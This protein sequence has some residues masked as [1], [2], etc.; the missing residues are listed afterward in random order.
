MH[1]HWV[2]KT[3]AVIVVL[4][5]SNLE[6]ICSGIS[7]NTIPDDCLIYSGFNLFQFLILRP[8]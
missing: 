6:K 8:L 7:I 3:T 1:L 4:T 5:G 2:K